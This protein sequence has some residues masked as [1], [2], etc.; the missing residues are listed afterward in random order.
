MAGV[1]Y[2]ATHPRFH[3]ATPRRREARE[4]VRVAI[5]AAIS[6]HRLAEARVRRRCSAAQAEWTLAAEA[7]ERAA[8]RVIAAEPENA[9][10]AFTSAP[11]AYRFGACFVVADMAARGGPDEVTRAFRAARDIA[12]TVGEGAPLGDRAGR[13]AKIALETSAEA[14]LPA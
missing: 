2:L 12:A 6:R 3:S 8:R 7:V 14:E 13:R 11:S 9:V 1:A 10:R 5:G 4:P